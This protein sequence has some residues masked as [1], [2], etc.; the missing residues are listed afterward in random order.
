MWI[1]NG[2]LEDREERGNIRFTAFVI[3]LVNNWRAL[4]FAASFLP[5]S[6]LMVAHFEWPD[7]TT[8]VLE[9]HLTPWLCSGTAEAIAR[10]NAVAKR[11]RASIE[12]LGTVRRALESN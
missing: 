12:S 10:R 1:A 9:R 7:H 6:C 11:G 5:L 8:G 2:R 4:L 3:S